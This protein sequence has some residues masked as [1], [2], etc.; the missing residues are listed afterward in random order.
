M[1]YTLIERNCLKQA[2]SFRLNLLPDI[3]GNQDICN[4]GL[5]TFHQIVGYLKIL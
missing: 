1:T 3:G 5:S 4:K 2:E